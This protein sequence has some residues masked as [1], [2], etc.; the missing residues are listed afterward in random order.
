MVT[1]FR[2]FAVSDKQMLL[3]MLVDEVAEPGLNG[4]RAILRYRRAR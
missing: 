1:T 2:I 4:M 3:V